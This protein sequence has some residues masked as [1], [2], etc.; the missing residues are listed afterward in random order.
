[1]KYRLTDVLACPYDKT[2]PL[3]LVVL[4]RA[5]HPE[6]QYTWPR[7]PFCEEYCAYRD[8]KI[9]EHPKPDALPCEECH[10]WEIETG[11]IYCPTC[12]RWFPIIEEIPRM[13]PD[14]LRNEK[15]E[16]AFLES[17]AQDLRK[18]APDT[19]DKILTQGKPFN[20]TNKK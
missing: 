15:E 7:K 16:L 3:R 9:K 17:V 14:E 12:G 4:K 5:E 6:R 8:L 18:A 1:M 10:R 13:L 11:V 19:A 2:F 20:L